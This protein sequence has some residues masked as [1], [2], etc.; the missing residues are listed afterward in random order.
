MIRGKIRHQD[1]TSKSTKTTSLSNN[2]EL[3]NQQHEVT[4]RSWRYYANEYA[5]RNSHDGVV[6]DLPENLLLKVNELSVL[7]ML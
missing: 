3:L 7:K 2:T 4:R 6:T 1:M 5:S